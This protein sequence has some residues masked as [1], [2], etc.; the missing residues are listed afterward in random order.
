MGAVT[1]NKR[2]FI[3]SLPECNITV[4]AFKPIEKHMLVDSGE[5]KI[6]GIKF[7][8][9]SILNFFEDIRLGNTKRYS[10]E[11]I[12][13]NGFFFV[14]ENEGIENGIKKPLN[15]LHVGIMK[16]HADESLLRLLP[17]KLIDHKGPHF[18]APDMEF[19]GFMGII[20]ANFFSEHDDCGEMLRNLGF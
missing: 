16:E 17:E 7:I 3:R 10:Y 20:V 11:Y 1:P 6:E 13:R 8:D 18:K 2:Y 19:H 9:G 15:H 5:I 4:P 12:Q 14:Y